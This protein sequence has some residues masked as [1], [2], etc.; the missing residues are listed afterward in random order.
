MK[1]IRGPPVSCTGRLT[2][3]TAHRSRAQTPLRWSPQVA[4]PLHCLAASTGCRGHRRPPYLCTW[5]ERSPPQLHLLPSR[6]SALPCC[7]ITGGATSFF[8]AECLHV[9]GPLRPSFG[10]VSTSS[11]SAAAPWTSSSTSQSP[12]ARGL[13][14]PSSF[15]SADPHHRGW[16]HR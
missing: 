10:P 16:A 15:P 12:L 1:W 13:P 9:D 2:T 3:P 11:S 5:A 4:H 8:T 14:L 7:S 6:P